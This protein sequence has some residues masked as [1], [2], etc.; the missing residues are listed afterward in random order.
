MQWT[1]TLLYACAP[2]T[3]SGLQAGRIASLEKSQDSTQ[4]QDFCEQI[5]IDKAGHIITIC[6]LL[7]RDWMFPRGI[8]TDFI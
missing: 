2:T 4:W 8:H 1:Y 3:K 6:Q 7:Q 5:P